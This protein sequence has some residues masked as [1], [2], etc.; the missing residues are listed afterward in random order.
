[1][2][3]STPCIETTR[4]RDAKG[5]GRCA[6][7]R[8]GVNIRLTHRLA[9][10]DHHGRLPEPGKFILHHCDNPPCMNVEHLYEGTIKENSRD[11]V[12][13][14]RGRSGWA[15]AKNKAKTR[16][17]QGHEYTPENTYVFH[18]KVRTSLGGFKSTTKRYC[19]TCRSEHDRHRNERRTTKAAAR[20]DAELAATE[21]LSDGTAWRLTK[22]QRRALTRIAAEPEMNVAAEDAR[23]V[24]SLVRRGL[25]ARYPD[26]WALTD[27]GRA[28]LDA[29][30]FREGRGICP[31]CGRSTRL[32]VGGT[33]GRHSTRWGQPGP[34]C[35]GRGLLPKTD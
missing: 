23:T 35:A 7:K 10:I 5:Y 9:W 15:A 32:L 31:S 17:P 24:R 11:M 22:A 27:S 2:I 26:G 4:A 13:R 8:F 25:A 3:L 21:V 18:T 34:S 14:G 20:R 29:A 12:L 1:M 6:V 16:C 33:I 19:L 30:S 28:A